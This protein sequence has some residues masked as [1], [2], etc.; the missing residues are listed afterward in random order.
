VHALTGPT[1]AFFGFADRGV[2]APG[3]ASDLAVVALDDIEL[4][5]EERR[6]EMPHGTWRFT[7]PPAGFRATIVTGTATWL[8]GEATGSRPG[9]VLGPLDPDRGGRL[10][11]S[12]TWFAARLERH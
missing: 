7:R 4:R 6:Y 11:A 5:R 10:K 1:A 9:P 3:N 2:V 8:N 12:F